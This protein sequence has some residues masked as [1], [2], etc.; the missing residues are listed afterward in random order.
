ML[1][2]A[3]SPSFGQCQ[4]PRSLV[5]EGSFAKVKT[6][7]L[8]LLGL[9]VLAGVFAGA[10]LLKKAVRPEPA[11]TSLT[12]TASSRPGEPVHNI[13]TVRRTFENMLKGAPE[14]AVFFE[15]LKADFP[16]EYESFLTAVAQ[17]SAASGEIGSADLHLAEAVRS[18]R[19]SR[20]VLA[21]KAGQAALEHIFELQLAMLKALAARDPRL[22]ADYLYG[23]ESS[24]YLEFAAQNR[25]L[26]AEM[27]VAGVDAI[28]DG[29]LKRVERDAPT[30]GEFD[31][32]EQMLR[33][34]G[35]GS[36]EIEAL[37]D[38]TVSNPPISDER[39]CNAGQVYLETLATMPEESR[40]RIYGLA[41]ELMARS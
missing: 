33:A 10:A 14:Y 27:A 37:L 9:A 22:C 4:T 13:E 41:V 26:V 2:L 18:L 20:G 39:M 25:S 5:P 28:H 7:R 3:R 29:E 6:L 32:L 17:R 34:K 15:R 31:A 40:L 16:S 19:L 11:S 38:G 36:Q 12:A 23:G 21:A 8:V 24:G 1:G 35:L 30:V